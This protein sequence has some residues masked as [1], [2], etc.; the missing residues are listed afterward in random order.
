MDKQTVGNGLYGLQGMKNDCDEVRG[1]LN[2]IA[3]KLEA[4][5]YEPKDSLNKDS[6]QVT[7]SISNEYEM[8]GQ[9]IGNALWGMKNMSPE[10]PGKGVKLLSSSPPPKKSNI[11]I[12]APYPSCM[13]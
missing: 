9:N 3:S 1:L 11:C 4:M 5:P 10:S 8:T 7:S 13:S 6:K 12:T 2:A